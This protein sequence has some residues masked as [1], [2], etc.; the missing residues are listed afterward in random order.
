MCGQSIRMQ[1]AVFASFL[2]RTPDGGW[3]KSHKCDTWVQGAAGEVAVGGMGAVTAL[4]PSCPHRSGY[5]TVYK[6][7]YRMEQQTVY[8][9]CPGWAQQDDEPGCLHCELG[10]NW[11]KTT[12]WHPQT[13]PSHWIPTSRYKGWLLVVYNWHFPSDEGVNVL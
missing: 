12:K 2:M 3:K 5:Y 6:Q 8:K 11:D 9:C 4:W 1:F 10:Q 7:V 13:L